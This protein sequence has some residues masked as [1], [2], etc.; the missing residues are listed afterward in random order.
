MT[1]SSGDD[2]DSNPGATAIIRDSTFQYNR[3]ELNN[4]GVAYLGDFAN[5][6]VEGDDNVFEMN[7][8]ETDGAVFAATS[9]SLVTVEGGSFH[10]NCAKVRDCTS[11]LA[12]SSS[13]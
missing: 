11:L 8:C 3:A 13:D 1:L 5:V 7:T 9:N 2:F 4:G 10:N 12:T 6:I